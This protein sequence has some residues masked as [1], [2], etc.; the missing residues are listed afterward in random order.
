MA[1]LPL[2][3]NILYF[4]VALLL[5]LLTTILLGK[6]IQSK[7]A[8]VTQVQKESIELT[9][10][11]VAKHPLE[12]G[13]IIEAKDLK[14]VEWPTK[15]LPDSDEFHSETTKLAGRV[16]QSPMVAHEPILNAKLAKPNSQGGLPVLIPS[17]KRA[18]T[19]GVSEI[20]GVAGFIHPGNWVDVLA[21][22]ENGNDSSMNQTTHTVLQNVQVLAIAQDI[23]SK[24]KGGLL[25]NVNDDEE[26]EEEQSSAHR[27][28]NK[29]LT[30]EY[31]KLVTSVTLALSPQQV[32]KV[33]LADEAGS[34][35]LSLR[36]E[37]DRAIAP[38]SGTHISEIL[39]GRRKPTPAS[40]NRSTQPSS[41]IAPANT[42]EFYDG[43]ERSTLQF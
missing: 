3:S 29:P 27:F 19:V 7:N 1:G 25:P 40:S 13:H 22:F 10:I 41:Y 14:T 15:H 37:D 24:K 39:T 11:V 31:A 12:A 33:I 30:S 38:N 42:V 26:D 35:R 9:D 36:G 8:T 23:H 4:G 21:T 2:K 28:G 43:T 5:A 18:I 20:I 17:G 34:L 6:F 16:V 32:E